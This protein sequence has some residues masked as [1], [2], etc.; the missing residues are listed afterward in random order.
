MALGKKAP[1]SSK[2]SAKAP[3]SSKLSKKY[4]AKKAAA[5][6]GFRPVKCGRGFVVSGGM[7]RKAI[8]VDTVDFDGESYVKL[9]RCESWLCHAAAS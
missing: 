1:R 9:G 7:L 2:C 3:R 4:R 6:K 5:G 8:C